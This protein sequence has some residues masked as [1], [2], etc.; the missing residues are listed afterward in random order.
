[1]NY[2]YHDLGNSSD[3]DVYMWEPY[4][5]HPLDGA[6]LLSNNT[7][8]YLINGKKYHLD[9]SY[10]GAALSQYDVQ[11]GIIEQQM[12]QG[13]KLSNVD[14]VSELWD[15]IYGSHYDIN[16]PL[17]YQINTIATSKSSLSDIYGSDVVCAQLSQ[18]DKIGDVNFEIWGNNAYNVG[19]WTT[20]GVQLTPLFTGGSQPTKMLPSLTLFDRNVVWQGGAY[21]A[22]WYQGS[23][24]TIS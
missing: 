20:S 10:Y 6:D 16:S 9:D 7:K 4:Y 18:S 15:T 5:A 23:N 13:C 1:M 8:V 2:S 21:G 22:E 17:L 3:D 12:S 14:A 19:V 24:L 11:P